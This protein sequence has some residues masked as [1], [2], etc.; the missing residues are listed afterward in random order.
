MIIYI[1]ND[2]R[3]NIIRSNE[4]I[5]KLIID[6]TITE[7]T[8]L[9]TDITGDWISAKD[10]KLYNE[11]IG[12]SQ[13]PNEE[14][15]KVQQQKQLQEDY[16][17]ALKDPTKVSLFKEKWSAIG[18][19]KDENS[20]EY[21]LILDTKDFNKSYFWI[22][23]LNDNYEFFLGKFLYSNLAALTA[24]GNRGAKELFENIYKIS[25]GSEFIVSKKPFV[26]QNN[27]NFIISSKGELSLPQREIVKVVKTK[28][29]NTSSY[30]EDVSTINQKKNIQKD[31]KDLNKQESQKEELTKKSVSK[32]TKK[33][34][35][36][37]EGNNNINEKVEEKKPHDGWGFNSNKK[38]PQSRP[39]KFKYII[40][41]ILA[42]WISYGAVYLASEVLINFLT[43]EQLIYIE[44]PIES[45]FILLVWIFIY[46]LFGSL[47]IKKVMPWM[48]GLT[49]LAVIR[50][51]SQGVVEFNHLNIDYPP[52]LGISIIVSTIIIILLFKKYFESKGRFY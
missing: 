40:A 39:S 25:E 3:E 35:T 52:Q 9:K 13:S 32:E 17:A 8:L 24:D 42:S 22:V 38:S 20:R 30:S 14:E 7:K 41:W 33:V 10:Y 6:N 19:K 26:K 50:N 28:I 31:K 51:I 46:T 15:N 21:S 12:I 34:E 29:N 36:I 18:L 47:N 23:L 27:N 16:G 2:G 45:I 44:A 11:I 1:D 5:R 49:T 43:Y 37:K 4:L 48:W